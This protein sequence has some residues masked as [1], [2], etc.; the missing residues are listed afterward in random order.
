TG[1]DEALPAETI[2]LVTSRAKEASAR[3]AVER[4]QVVAAAVAGARDLVNTS[5]LDLLPAAFADHA[6]AAATGTKVKVSVLDEKQL[7]A[8]GYGGLIAVG[9]GSSRPPRLVKLTWSPSKATRSVSLVGKGITFDSGG[10][11]IKPAKG[12]ETMKSDM[13]GAAAVLHTVLAAAA[14]ELPVKVT[15]W[16]CLAEN[17]PS[18]T[19]QR[20]SDVITQ[21]GGTTVE[22]LNAAAEGRLV[23]ADGLVAA[24]GENP[25][26]V[27]GIA[28]LTGAQLVA[29]GPRVSAVLGTEYAR[30]A[31]VDAA[32]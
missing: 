30:T 4:A 7:A 17:M 11:S 28:T 18:G 10:L 2:E 14:L 21:R 29:L 9:Q 20:P 27:V 26:L 13:A 32:E 16:L 19:G 3:A 5:P 15:G 24:C 1:A 12:M 25:D 23:V 8:G 22:V 31:V 6:K